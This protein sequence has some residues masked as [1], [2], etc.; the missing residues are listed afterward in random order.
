MKT[1]K[2]ICSEEELD[3]ALRRF[4]SSV[5]SW[6]EAEYAR[7]RRLA[8]GGWQ[9]VRGFA[10]GAAM[11][12]LVAVCVIPLAIRHGHPGQSV[13]QAS[14]SLAS[15]SEAS[16]RPAQTGPAQTSPAQTSPA[17]TGAAPADRAETV[18]EAA[19][20]P[21]S[22]RR[23]RVSDQAQIAKAER[24]GAASAP[25]NQD[26]DDELMASIDN[27]L[28]QR[29]PRALAPLANLMSDSAEQ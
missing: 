24:N 8:V 1:P 21:Q 27:E 9:R 2:N 19:A 5:Q 4:R 22:P 11:A 23:E 25:A 14:P 17:Q 18:G 16:A 12:S 6:S 20:S 3:Q 13:A 26:S 15:A 29:T 28:A 7:P 10:L